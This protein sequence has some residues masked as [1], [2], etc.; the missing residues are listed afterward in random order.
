M[1]NT[2]EKHSKHFLGQEMKV[3]IPGMSCVYLI[4]EGCF[5][6]AVFLLKNP[7]ESVSCSLVLNSLRPPGVQ[8]TSLLCPCNSPGK[9]TGVG[10]HSL[11]QGIFPIQGLNYSL[12][13][14]RWILCHLSPQR[15]PSLCMHTTK[16]GSQ[17]L[18]YT[19]KLRK[20]GEKNLPIVYLICVR[21][22]A[23]SVYLLFQYAPFNQ[24]ILKEISPEYS[25]G[26][27]MLKLK[28]QS[29]GHLM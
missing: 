9:N 18:S 28:L 1:K 20:K 3:N 14:C 21:H 23:M 19:E 11:L 5:A 29:F 8:P 24:P 4:Q 6:S 16:M 13:H 7:C 17:G 15:S 2:V 27:L 10:C 12:L 25:L 22:C 26:G